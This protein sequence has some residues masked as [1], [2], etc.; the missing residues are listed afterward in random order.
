MAADLSDK[1]ECSKAVCV[2]LL[3]PNAIAED[4]TESGIRLDVLGYVLDL[5]PRL[6]S[7]SRKNF[8]NAVYGFFTTELD[9]EISLATALKL[10][11]R[12]SRYSK[13]CRAVTLE[14]KREGRSK[15]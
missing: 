12:G 8:M 14:G 3:G 11:S 15:G 7:I 6:A 13:I 2:D 4:K 9:K 10:A 1:I 5:G